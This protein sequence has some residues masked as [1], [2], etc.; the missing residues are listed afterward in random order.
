[1]ILVAATHTPLV[2]VLAIRFIWRCGRFWHG[3]PFWQAE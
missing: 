2:A 1:M 3:W